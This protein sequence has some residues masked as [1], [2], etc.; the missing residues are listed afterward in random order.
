MLRLQAREHKEAEFEAA[1]EY[2]MAHNTNLPELPEFPSLLILRRKQGNQKYKKWRPMFKQ[3]NAR[4]A[5]GSLKVLV[6]FVQVRLIAPL[7]VF[8]L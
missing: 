8:C 7:P 3:E 5:L 6:S 1:V 4:I 2:S